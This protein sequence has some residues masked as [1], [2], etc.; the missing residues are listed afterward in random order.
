MIHRGQGV[1]QGVTQSTEFSAGVKSSPNGSLALD[2]SRTRL[3]LRSLNMVKKRV[4]VK[5]E[6]GRFMG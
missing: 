2:S 6:V 5:K 3:I 1:S 4:R